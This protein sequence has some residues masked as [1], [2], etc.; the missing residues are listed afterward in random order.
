LEEYVAQPAS[1]RRLAFS[2]ALERTLAEARKAPLVLYQLLPPAVAIVAATAFAEPAQADLARNE[3]RLIL[4]ALSDCRTCHGDLLPPR[5]SCSHCGNP[6][7]KFAW[8]TGE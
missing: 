8:L 1:G 2:T 5:T 6:L 7:W 3:Q 4:P